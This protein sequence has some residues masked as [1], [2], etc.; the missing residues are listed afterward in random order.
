MNTWVT[1]SR[2]GGNP[3][4]QAAEIDV[5]YIGPGSPYGQ[6]STLPDGSDAD[7]DLRGSCAG[8]GR[9]RGRTRPEHSS[10]PLPLDRP[11]QDLDPLRLHGPQ[12]VQRNLPPALAILR[13]SAAMRT[14]DDQGV[15]V[16][17]ATTR[18]KPGANR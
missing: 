6:T 9:G 16:L 11:G 12:A 2:D 1:R 17:A 8:E 13:L 14:A 5:S 18:A 7:A 4:S 15:C 3:W 10:P